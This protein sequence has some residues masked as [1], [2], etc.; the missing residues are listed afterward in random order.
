MFWGIKKKSYNH[1]LTLTID[2]QSKTQHDRSYLERFLHQSRH[3]NSPEYFKSG[4]SF[5]M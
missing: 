1:Q 3:F 4:Y 5:A 2:Y